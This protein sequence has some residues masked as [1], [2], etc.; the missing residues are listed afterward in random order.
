M[1]HLVLQQHLLLHLL[2]LLLQLQQQMLGR[3]TPTVKRVFYV[4]SFYGN[5]RRGRFSVLLCH[6]E[7]PK[8]VHAV[9]ISGVQTA[10]QQQQWRRR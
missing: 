3:E 7:S 2:P 8:E 10:Q 5:E 9:F 6:K 1:L 4:L